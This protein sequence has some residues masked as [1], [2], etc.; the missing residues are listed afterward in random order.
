VVRIANHACEDVNIFRVGSKRFWN[1]VLRATNETRLAF[2]RPLRAD[3]VRVAMRLRQRQRPYVG[4]T[5][6]TTTTLLLLY[7]GVASVLPLAVSLTIAARQPRIAMAA[8]FSSNAILESA[9]PANEAVFARVQAVIFD[10]DGTLADSGEL[11]FNA[12]QV[13]LQKNGYP[14][15]SHDEY[16]HGTRYTTPDRL[17]RH[18]GLTPTDEGFDELGQ[19]LG[20]EF[21]DLYIDLVSIETAALYPGMRDLVRRI[22][23]HVRVGALTNAAG[24]Y[25]H[26]VLVVNNVTNDDDDGDFSLYQR[27]GSILGADNVPKPKPFADGLWQVCQELQIENPSRCVFIGDSPSDGLAA[28]AAGMPCIGVTWGAHPVER[29]QPHVAYICTTVPELAALLPQQR[30]I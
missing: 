12:T 30:Q 26:A 6:T 20:R 10:I 29:L 23:D 1:D 8:S 3:T 16:N 9:Y 14:L 19:M 7:C 18:A 25:A 5:T 4:C 17:A 11:G 27:F 13:I 15:I 28:A 2:G 22:P 24:R 21:D